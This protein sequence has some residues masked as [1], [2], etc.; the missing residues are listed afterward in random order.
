MFCPH[1]AKPHL[2]TTTQEIESK[3]TQGLFF[4]SNAQTFPQLYFAFGS[5]EIFRSVKPMGPVLKLRTQDGAALQLPQTPP[6]V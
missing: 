1:G 3:Y 4:V 6:R 2:V 5:K